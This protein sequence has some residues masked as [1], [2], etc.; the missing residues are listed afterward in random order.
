QNATSVARL[1]A[2]QLAFERQEQPPV[3]IKSDYWK[4]PE[5]A[6]VSDPNATTP[7]RKGLTGSTR[8]L[9]DIEL[10]A[11]Y[12]IDTD[13]RKLHVSKI[14]SLAQLA[15]LEFELFRQNGVLTIATPMD[16]FD[17]DFPGQYLRLIKRVR[18]SLIALIPPTAGI[19]ATLT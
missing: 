8:L 11:Q 1:A 15:P 2:S 6:T 5:D 9:S 3:L 16:M 14:I 17:Q 10:L 7:D 19:K 12:A 4:A 13:E 18:V